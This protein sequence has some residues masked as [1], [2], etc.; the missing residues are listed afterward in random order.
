M[1]SLNFSRARHKGVGADRGIC[2]GCP[3]LKR[4][5]ERIKF[6]PFRT[7]ATCPE[8]CGENLKVKHPT[9]TR[10]HPYVSLVRKSIWTHIRRD[11]VQ[12]HSVVTYHSFNIH[13][14]P[15][16]SKTFVIGALQKPLVTLD[17]FLSNRRLRTP[18][19]ASTRPHGQ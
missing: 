12:L 8:Q 9:D 7:L 4:Q 17:R 3:C 2:R 13:W 1:L 18:W 15:E 5:L 6:E 16:R 10:Q 14:S 11:V 19:A